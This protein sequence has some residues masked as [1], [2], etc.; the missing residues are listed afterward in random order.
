ML[1]KLWVKVNIVGHHK[2]THA[3]SSLLLG[4]DTYF[5]F[6]HPWFYLQNI[7]WIDLLLSTSN[8]G[9]LIQVTIIFCLGLAASN[10][11]SSFP[12]CQPK[13]SFK[14]KSHNIISQLK[15]HLWCHITLGIWTKFL[16][17]P[18]ASWLP[19]SCHTFLPFTLSVPLI[20]P[21]PQHRNL[22]CVFFLPENHL[23]PLFT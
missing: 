14:I 13:G 17:L 15:T 1:Q 21:G 16:T 7:S 6:L 18:I 9:T 22:A 11:S 3:G 4:P 10:S 19:S 2:D 20:H 23:L 5:P 12:H 8:P